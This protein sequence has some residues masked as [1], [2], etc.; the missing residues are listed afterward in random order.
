MERIEIDGR[1]YALEHRSLDGPSFVDADDAS[2]WVAG[3]RAV[4][5]LTPV[6]DPW[7]WYRCHLTPAGW[8]IAE[9]I[10][11]VKITQKALREAL[12]SL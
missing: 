1:S 4:A 6:L 8:V 12:A 3:V 7:H 5:I 10:G 11:D 9:F 2:L